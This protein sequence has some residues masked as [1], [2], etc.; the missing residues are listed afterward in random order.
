MLNESHRALRR[1][2]HARMGRAAILLLTWL[3]VTQQR[4]GAQFN[5]DRFNGFESG[6]AGDYEI[7]AGA[8]ASD[9][10]AHSG[11]RGLLTEA[12]AGTNEFVHTPFSAPL[13]VV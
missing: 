10:N 2:R 11:E 9:P 13:F 1:M 6:G 3:V 5:L 4:A 12:D 8:P 7:G